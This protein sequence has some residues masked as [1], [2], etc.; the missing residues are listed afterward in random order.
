MKKS[1]LLVALLVFKISVAYALPTVIHT[2]EPTAPSGPVRTSANILDG[3]ANLTPQQQAELARADQLYQQQQAWTTLMHVVCSNK[4]SE[5]YSKD[6]WRNIGG[7]TNS[8]RGDGWYV[9]Q[10]MR[11]EAQPGGVIFSGAYSDTLRVGCK[12]ANLPPGLTA[13]QI[14][15]NFFPGSDITVN[16]ITYKPNYVAYVDYGLAQGRGAEEFFVA[17]FPYPSAQDLMAHFEGFYTYTNSSG[18]PITIKKFNYGVCCEKLWTPEELAVAREHS[19]AQKNVAATGALKFE[20]SQADKGDSYWLFHLGERYRDG[21]GVPK[22]LDKARDYF[23]RAKKAG[24]SNAD[25]ELKKL[26]QGLTDSASK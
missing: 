10:G 7:T 22:D 5:I 26:N 3:S 25:D 16:Y 8:A 17:N 6:V 19:E 18:Y 12:M 9:F 1:F 23:E 24:N 2:A 13:S 21:N 15:G 14:I 20:Q 11:Q 4:L